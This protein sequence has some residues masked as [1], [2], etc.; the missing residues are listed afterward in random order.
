VN[1]I[2]NTPPK[3]IDLKKKKKKKK[4][5]LKR[6]IGWGRQ[7]Q[8]SLQINTTQCYFRAAVAG[9]LATSV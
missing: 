9:R 2:S 8:N 3:H 4:Q 6:N 1:S 7:Q 5:Q